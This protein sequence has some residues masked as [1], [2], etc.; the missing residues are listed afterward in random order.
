MPYKNK[1]TPEQK[2]LKKNR[3]RKWREKNKLL[4]VGTLLKG[5]Q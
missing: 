3:Q 2:D 1:L 5:G 4:K